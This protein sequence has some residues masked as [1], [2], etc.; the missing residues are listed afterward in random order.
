MKKVLFFILCFLASS[1]LLAQTDGVGSGHAIK[2][3]AT[4]DYIDLGNVYDDLSFP[5]TISA[6]VYVE[7]S[8]QY[9]LP[10]FA[11]QDNAP[12]Y[13]GLWFCLS[14]TNLFVEYGDGRGEQNAAYRKGKS[15][16]IGEYVNRW[17]H[18]SAVIKTGNDIQLYVNGSNVGGA[19][20]GLSTE[21]MASN[22]PNDV[23]KIGALF[24]NSTQHRYKGIID[25]LRFWNRALT[26]YEIRVTMCQRL[27][28]DESGLI[29]YWNFDETEGDQ[30]KDLSPRGYDGTL[31]GN[32]GRIFSG[33]PL[34][35]E[36]VFLYTTSW[37][38]KTLSKNGLTISNISANVKGAHIYTVNHIP[39]QTGGLEVSELQI[40]YYGVFLADNGGSN[41]FDLAFGE[42]VA[43]QY[44]ERKDNS[45]SN[46]YPS[47]VFSGI[48]GRIEIIPTGQ[49]ANE[50]LEVNLGPD[51]ILCDAET[52]ELQAHQQ[53][54]GKTFFWSTGATTPAITVSTSGIFS[55][56]VQSDCQLE[57]D[58]IQVYFMETPPDF[59]LGEDEL[60]CDFEPRM[61]SPDLENTGFS[62]TWQDGSKEPS[63][64]AEAFGT[65]I[66]KLQ[67]A[68]GTSVDSINLIE[69][70]EADLNVSLGQDVTLCDQTSHELNG[71]PDHS[72]K[73][74]LW[75]T[76]HTSP[77]ITVTSSGDF[78]VEVSGQCNL[79]RD[80]VHVAFFK[81]PPV[82]SLGVDE[83]LCEFEPRTLSVDVASQ[84]FRFF[85][86]DDSDE[87]S[88]IADDF[89]TYWVRVENACGVST[90]TITFTKKV[91]TD[92]DTYNFISPDN[93]D[94]RNQFFTVD[95][96][97][98]GATLSVYNR[99]GKPVFQS[100][101]YQNNWDGDDLPSGVY[102]YTI[103][104]PC[105]DPLKGTLTIMR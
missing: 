8:T 7:P 64:Y 82:F 6:W 22:F 18:V 65:F 10:I 16:S 87:S 76:G 78:W 85:W 90:D 38:G 70:Q 99:W 88:F 35:D 104:D 1:G 48:I 50:P 89:G 71:H 29:G 40:P 46:W 4:D 12:I 69:I 72:G 58:T 80:T 66:L 3:D 79:E 95:E 73:T 20:T 96:R 14:A 67:N 97:L 41:T 84:D 54:E 49:E 52:Y 44:F 43:C 53:P 33:A 105:I 37:G 5:V 102:F 75:S 31:K 100:S 28:G 9:I 86:Q 51:V 23:A 15:A 56:M 55:V 77:A 32:P 25:E 57:K 27:K 19:Y 74:F 93:Q 101:G 11:T 83:L 91:F 21:P 62:F 26:E 2:F 98:V 60:M 103:Q 30:L 92:L 61:L 39:S 68:C 63:F 24:T 59:S 17:I 94:D 47:E 45:E 81:T 42:G 34:G 36:S 13:N